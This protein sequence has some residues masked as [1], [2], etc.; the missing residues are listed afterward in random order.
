MDLLYNY[1]IYI[2]FTYKHPV[3]FCITY[4]LADEQ[5]QVLAHTAGCAG[6]AHSQISHADL[7]V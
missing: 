5:M 1:L 3:T 4:I 6:S 7:V 2:I